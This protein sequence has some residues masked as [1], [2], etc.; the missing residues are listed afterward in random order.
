MSQE[1]KRYSVVVNGEVVLET[2]TKREAQRRHK[3]ELKA[4]HGE[5]RFNDR[6]E[7]A[8]QVAEAIATDESMDDELAGL[9]DGFEDHPVNVALRRGD[10]SQAQWKRINDGKISLEEVEA[11]NAALIEGSKPKPPKAEREKKARVKNPFS[12]YTPSG[13]IGYIGAQPIVMTRRH[14]AVVEL[15]GGMP[16]MITSAHVSARK[17]VEVAVEKEI[18]AADSEKYVGRFDPEDGGV[19]FKSE[20]P[21]AVRDYIEETYGPGSYKRVETASEK[22]QRI[23]AEKAAE[24]ARL[25][26]ERKNSGKVA[27][28]RPREK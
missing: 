17:L 21:D 15:I 5:V 22:K 11:E 3:K 4:E 18:F 2:N 9:G 7:I 23:D 19:I 1:E 20:V 12:F 8:R 14:A 25:S 6:D 16:A 26:E 28:A 24:K 13:Q 10:I 27:Q